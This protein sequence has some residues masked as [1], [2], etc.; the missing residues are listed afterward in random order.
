MWCA[1]YHSRGV[2]E[3]DFWIFWIRT[4]AAS[5]RIRREVFFAVVRAELDLDFVFFEIQ[6]LCLIFIYAESNKS[7]IAS[8]Y[9]VPDPVSI[10][11]GNLQTRIGFGL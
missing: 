1:V 2:R 11:T 6:V 3:M 5:N 9:L 4:P 8:V 10:G 7:R